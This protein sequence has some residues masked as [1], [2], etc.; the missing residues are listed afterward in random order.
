[1]S[2]IHPDRIREH[3]WSAL[4]TGSLPDVLETSLEAGLTADAVSRRTTLFGPNT[5]PAP[6]TP[7]WLWRFARELANPLT[8][9]LALAVALTIYLGDYVDAVVIGAVIV[10]NASIG[11]IQEYRAENALAAVNKLLSPSCR[12][13]RGGTTLTLPVERLVP[14]DVVL[15]EA[16]AGVPA[17]CRLVQVDGLEVDES[18][19]TGESAPVAKSSDALAAG[20][21]LAERSNM[22]FA[23]TTVTRGAARGV[24]VATGGRTE[25]GAIG[26]MVRQ[27]RSL[28]TPLTQRLDRLAGQITAAVLVISAI[29]LLWGLFVNQLD[30][31]F[32]IIAIVGLAVG[33]I[34]EGLPAV[35]SFALAWSAKRLAALGALVRRL[36]A[37]EALGSVDVV[38]T[39]KTGTLTQNEMTVVEII[40]PETRHTVTG[41]GYHPDGEIQDFS[42]SMTAAAELLH[43]LSLCNDSDVA[44]DGDRVTVSGDP[45]ELALLTLAEKAGVNRTELAQAMP[46]V[47]SVPF[48][49]DNSY[50]ATLHRSG[51][52]TTAYL[53]GSPE[54]IMELCGST[55]GDDDRS[56]WEDTVTE[57]AGRG[58]RVLA[59]ASVSLPDGA[60]TAD[61]ARH[62]ARFLGLV[63]L[64][65][66]PRPD[67]IRALEECREAGVHVAMVTGDHADTAQA[68]ARELGL[69]HGGVLTGSDIDQM[70]DDEL[71]DRLETVTVIARAT[72]AHKLR[73]VTLSQARGHFVAMTGDGVN[74]APALRQ[75]HIGVAMGDKGTDA[76]RAAAD[77]VL[78]DD[79]F[80]TISHAIREGRRVYDN[81][82]KSL[83]FLLATDLDEAALIMLAILFGVS[84]PVTPTQILWVNLVTSVALSFALIV[85]RAE[86]TVM[87]RGPNPKSLS[88]IT[89]SM[90]GRILF[91][92][93]LSVLATFAVFYE[94]LAEGVPLAQAQ[95]AAVTMLVVVEVAVLLNHRR[96]VAPA[97]GAGSVKGNRVVLTVIGVLLLLQLGFVYFPPLQQVF[98]S[99]A[100]PLESWAVVGA[101]ALG[102]FVAIEAEKWVRRRLGQKVF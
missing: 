60:T 68:I 27:V 44:I 16:G 32:I 70:S 6:Q 102:V 48:D 42:P 19:L 38:F 69:G 46:R 57:Q 51:N 29:T 96:F 2:A 33:A 53:K 36:P 87:K 66:P 47:G 75:A 1:M 12:V 55:L 95:T 89:W 31:Q 63:A 15:L 11:F 9:V 45:T 80:S 5:L 39:D 25:L 86:K 76:A 90:L 83:L 97:L 28:R 101:V 35:V 84:L 62:D 64:I 37:V 79:R 58:R 49:A 65:D 91:V 93:A 10:I 43:A 72:P 22:A 26:H 99:T 17:D 56:R 78:T 7:S 100:L 52:G 59:A 81:I 54:K 24:V 88:L 73:L 94:Q 40:T 23:G 67:A 92:S 98:G 21:P 13:I 74:D 85:E 3:E 34:P 14:G 8:A 71:G 4:Q 61:I 77:I 30:Q 18:A 41:V 82:K 50:M 20:V